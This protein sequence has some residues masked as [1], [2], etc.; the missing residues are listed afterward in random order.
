MC[1]SVC[2]YLGNTNLNKKNNNKKKKKIQKLIIKIQKKKSKQTAR[3]CVTHRCRRAPA[4]CRWMH[5]CSSSVLAVIGWDSPLTPA[6][7]PDPYYCHSDGYT[8]CRRHT[9]AHT[10][11]HRFVLF[12][13]VGKHTG[14]K[15]KEQKWS[16]FPRCVI[17]TSLSLYPS[18]F[19]A[20][21]LWYRGPQNLFNQG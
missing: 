2:V 7:P 14:E 21:H 16:E 13:C 6:D 15:L 18:L 1:L 12:S 4:G 8:P 10:H 9:H 17:I 3:R 5:Y 19:H 11:T 20:C